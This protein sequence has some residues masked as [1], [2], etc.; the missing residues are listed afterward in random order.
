MLVPAKFLELV[1]QSFYQLSYALVCISCVS[2]PLFICLFYRILVSSHQLS[3][4]IC[5]SSA[6]FVQDL[7]LK[8]GINTLVLAFGFCGGTP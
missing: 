8:V 3:I 7:N 6:D 4:R 2:Y 5:R 1:S